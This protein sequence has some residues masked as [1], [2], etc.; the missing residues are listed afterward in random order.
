MQADVQSLL[1]LC[2]CQGLVLKKEEVAIFVGLTQSH[3]LEHFYSVMLC[4]H[5]AQE[6]YQLL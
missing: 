1:E 3:S 6:L 5:L 2:S 4:M